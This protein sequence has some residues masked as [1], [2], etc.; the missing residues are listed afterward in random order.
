MSKRKER[1]AGDYSNRDTRVVALWLMNEQNNYNKIMQLDINSIDNIKIS[2]LKNHFVYTYE[3][4][5]WSQV[6]LDEIKD[7]IFETLKEQEEYNEK[8]QSLHLPNK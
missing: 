2:T 4:I 5:D 1:R 7:I 6:V 3:Q 8:Q